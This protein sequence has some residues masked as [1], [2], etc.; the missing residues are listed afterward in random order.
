MLEQT[1]LAELEAWM[2]ERHLGGHWEVDPEI[3]Y[4]P[5]PITTI[6]PHV[7][8]WRE[9]YEAAQGAGALVSLDA[10]ERRSVRLLNPGLRGRR[11]TTHTMQL[12][13]QL[14]KPGE[15]ARAHRHTP[16]AYR[17]VVQGSGAYTTVEGQQCRMEPGDLILTPQWTWH[18]HAND[19]DEPILWL[20][21]L[22]HPLITLLH[23]NMFEA[24]GTEV[25]PIRCTSDDVAPLF[26]AARPTGGPAGG[27][28]GYYHY[29]WRDTYPALKA[30]AARDEAVSAHDGAL[31][32]YVNPLTGG[33]TLPTMAHALQLLRPGETTQAHR[34]L[35]TTIYHVVRGRGASR[36]GEAEVTWERGDSFVVPVWYAH[37]HA[38]HSADE[39]A[40]L[41]S[42]TDAPVARAFGLY[43]EEA[44]EGR[45]PAR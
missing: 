41:F 33:P 34:H 44:C 27:A 31:L 36:I 8:R 26:G 10:A 6:R 15:V 25:Q 40:I 9:V 20:D 35:S 21:G 18:N 28:G 32:E 1:T 39:D 43:R 30:L 7:W 5:A 2:A 3:M 12:S 29:R 14:V 19:G 24:Y 16:A 38:N 13:V 45:A 23:L 11:F 17:F 42:V 22:D 37:A 4:A